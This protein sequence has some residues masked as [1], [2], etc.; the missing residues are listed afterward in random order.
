MSTMRFGV[1]IYVQSTLN[2]NK[3]SAIMPVFIGFPMTEIARDS[4]DL[5]DSCDPLLILGSDR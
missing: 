1:P 3:L 4:G 5:G 2:R